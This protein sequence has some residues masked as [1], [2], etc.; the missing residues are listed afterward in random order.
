MRSI[1]H[2]RLYFRLLPVLALPVFA[3]LILFLTISPPSH[4]IA[5]E[6]GL[7]KEKGSFYQRVAVQ[8]SPKF[9][10]NG[11]T[12]DQSLEYEVISRLEVTLSQGPGVLSVKHVV[13]RA[14]FGKADPMSR[15]TYAAALKNIVGTTLKYELNEDNQV[16][17]FVGGNASKKAISVGL[18]DSKGFVLTSLIDDDGWKELAAITFFHPPAQAKQWKTQ[19][20]HDWKPLGSWAGETTYA[21]GRRRGKGQIYTYQH[22]M[23]YRPPSD[24]AEKA[25]SL[26]FALNTAE[27]SPVRSAGQIMYDKARGRMSQAEEQFHVQG[28]VTATVLG[29]AAK[30]QLEERQAFLI[31]IEDQDT[32]KQ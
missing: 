5:Q 21:T 17:S 19:F 16:I 13:V 22:E 12:F 3:L 7:T 4:A 10:V 2:R 24:K 1:H 25:T 26:P 20:Y 15:S 11:L 27:F 9:A 23:K 30:I 32:W 18:P 29:Q 31:Q 14:N 28:I 8:R 6:Q